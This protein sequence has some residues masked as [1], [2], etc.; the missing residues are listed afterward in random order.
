MGNIRFGDLN[1]GGVGA[2]VAAFNHMDMFA[3]VMAVSPC[4]MN[5]S[6]FPDW[7][8]DMR[9]PVLLTKP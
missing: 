9:C 6:H 1:P 8:S 2:M 4:I 3:S 7:A 5:T